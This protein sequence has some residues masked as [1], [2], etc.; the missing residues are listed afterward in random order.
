[1]GHTL[2]IKN[3]SQARLWLRLLVTL[4]VTANAFITIKTV[5]TTASVAS[6]AAMTAGTVT[7]STTIGTLTIELNQ[8]TIRA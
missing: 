2:S 6:A 7:V 8:K 4:T 1:M 5:N 3:R